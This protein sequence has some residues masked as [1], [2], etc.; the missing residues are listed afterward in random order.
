V[1]LKVPNTRSTSPDDMPSLRSN[2]II[3]PMF[4]VAVGPKQP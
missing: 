2:G 4:G 3:A 1:T